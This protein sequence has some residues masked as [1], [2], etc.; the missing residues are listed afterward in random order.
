[1][2]MDVAQSTEHHSL[3]LL[4]RRTSGTIIGKQLKEGGERRP[5]EW[6]KKR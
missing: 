3:A 2:R 1:M 4:M 5:P 6:L